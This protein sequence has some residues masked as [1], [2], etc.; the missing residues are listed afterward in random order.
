M[1]SWIPIAV[2]SGLA[3]TGGLIATGISIYNRI[4]YEVLSYSVQVIGQNGM[5]VRIVF[6]VTNNSNYNVELWN[7]K[8]DV[9]VSGY[10]IAQI[11]SQ[12]RYL[13]LANNTSLLPL[14][15]DVFWD[16]LQVSAPYI[17]SQLQVTS[18]ASLPFVLH[19]HLAA[20]V[21]IIGLRKIP[22]RWTTTIGYFLP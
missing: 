20:K 13:L 22:V 4:Q 6:G 1:K 8:Y 2:G 10:K 14:D 17:G 18:I 7:Q 3:I 19:G 15:V 21:G 12:D 9:F 16:E 11:T 5:T